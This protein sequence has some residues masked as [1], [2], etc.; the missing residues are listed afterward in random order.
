MATVP[1]SVQQ[2]QD[3]IC[4][5]EDFL[6]RDGPAHSDN[7]F[8]QQLL[9][10]DEELT[11]VRTASHRRTMGQTSRVK[12]SEKALKKAHDNVVKM[13][14]EIKRQRR[15]IRD[16]KAQTA[17]LER[18]R[19]TNKLQVVAEARYRKHLMTISRKCEKYSGS[20][21]GTFLD[22]NHFNHNFPPARRQQV[23]EKWF[24]WVK[25]ELQFAAEMRE[26]FKRVDVDGSSTGA[27]G[28]TRSKRLCDDSSSGLVYGERKR[29]RF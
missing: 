29:L 8:R 4:F 11:R 26:T 5:F 6:Y 28:S 14:D 25:K 15:Q 2:L 22:P 19:S 27:S 18:E 24:K 23:E 13:E 10:I 3:N 20:V 16:L 12:Q 1:L 17:Q 7:A 9:A 21:M